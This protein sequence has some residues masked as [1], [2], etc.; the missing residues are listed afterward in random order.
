MEPIREAVDDAGMLRGDVSRFVLDIVENCTSFSHACRHVFRGQG[1]LRVPT[2]TMLRWIVSLY[3]AVLTVEDHAPGSETGIN[4]I[5][6]R[7]TAPREMISERPAVSIRRVSSGCEVEKRRKEIQYRS[8]RVAH[9]AT[10]NPRSCH[11]ER[12]AD[13]T[14]QRG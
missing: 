5:S 1:H 11:D 8:G 12:D 10:S 4:D 3:E 7:V 14:H 2:A 6:W 13:R 9:S